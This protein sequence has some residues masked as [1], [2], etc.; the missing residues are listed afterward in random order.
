MFFI[1]FIILFFERRVRIVI[2]VV[3]VILDISVFVEVYL[4]GIFVY[5][6]F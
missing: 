2:G 5:I 6:V 1:F 3:R 4:V